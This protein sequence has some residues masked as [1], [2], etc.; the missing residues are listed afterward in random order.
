MASALFDQIV[1]GAQIIP[2][3]PSRDPDG[4][5]LLHVLQPVE[6]GR[7]YRIDHSTFLV[8]DAP[9][10][11]RLTLEHVRYNTVLLR[12]EKSGSLLTLDATTGQRALPPDRRR[13]GWRAGSWGFFDQL[14]AS[15]REYPPAPT[16]DDPTTAPD[17]TALLEAKALFV[18]SGRLN[19][20]ANVP[21]GAWRGVTVNRF[22]GRVVGLNLTQ[23]GLGV[24]FRHRWPAP[25]GWNPSTSTATE[26]TGGIPPELGSLTNLRELDLG[27][28]PLGGDIPPELGELTN[29]RAL[30]L[31]VTELVGEIPE[32]LGSLELLEEL[33]IYGNYLEGCIPE[34]LRGFDFIIHGN[35]NPNLRWCGG[36]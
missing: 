2:L 36:R 33:T 13:R 22:T 8:V 32:E 9:E 5:E 14:A 12:D 6:G 7:S 11:M 17:C 30:N 29:L 26:L 16:C 23:M 19:W 28:N 27:E 10:G 21:I 25:R 31:Y 35:S 24:A 4:V 1:A 34:A 15:V 18:K 3:V 20:S